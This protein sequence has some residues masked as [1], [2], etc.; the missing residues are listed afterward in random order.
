MGLGLKI[1]AIL[2]RVKENEY[3]FSLF[4]ENVVRFFE[5]HPKLQVGELPIIHSV[6]SRLKNIDHLRGKIIRKISG[7]R[8]ITPENVFKEITDI[9]GVRVLHIYQNQLARIHAAIKEH[10]NNGEWVL[11]EDPKAYSWDP[12]A[13]EFFKTLGLNVEIKESHYTSVHYLVRPRPDAIV[14]CEIQVRTLFEEAW[15]EIDHAINYP[16]PT[17]RLS[18]REQLRVLA[19]LVGTGSRLADSIFK[20]KESGIVE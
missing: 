4:R 13:R 11:V 5:T 16:I 3:L 10:E 14:C 17:T 19:K 1:E 9:A 6:K 12:E 15:G 18:L 8:D 7:G 2:A 20:I